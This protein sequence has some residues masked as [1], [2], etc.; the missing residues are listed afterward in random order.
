VE[1]QRE[2]VAGRQQVL[3]Q[4]A[5]QVE[6]ARPWPERLEAEPQ[7]VA[8]RRQDPEPA[9][10]RQAGRRDGPVP[11]GQ[12]RETPEREP[13]R[14]PEQLVQQSTHLGWLSLPKLRKRPQ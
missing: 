11:R 13:M 3:E 6:P 2:I 10:Q 8:V 7:R 1:A 9:A 5:V 4:V 14:R 12:A